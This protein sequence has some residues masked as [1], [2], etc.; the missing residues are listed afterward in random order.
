MVQ[1]VRGMA[2]PSPTS[3]APRHQDPPRGVSPGVSSAQ[4]RPGQLGI[5]PTAPQGL[6]LPWA[7]ERLQIPPGA[8]ART[9]P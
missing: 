1:E 3:F 4:L 8:T 9:L 6:L 5:S 7:E 2:L